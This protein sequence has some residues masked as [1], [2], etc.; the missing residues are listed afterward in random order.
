MRKDIEH[1]ADALGR[2]GADVDSV[3]RAGVGERGSTV[4]RLCACRRAR[5]V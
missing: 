4:T 5:N 2:L 1:F 3:Q